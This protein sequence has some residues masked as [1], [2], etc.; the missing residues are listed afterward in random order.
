M[1]V[2][3]GAVVP[4]L[5]I[6]P[7]QH[8]PRHLHDASEVLELRRGHRLQEVM[9]ALQDLLTENS[10]SSRP[11]LAAHPLTPRYFA[12]VGSPDVPGE[13]AAAVLRGSGTEERIGTHDV[14]RALVTALHAATPVEHLV[15]TQQ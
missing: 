4:A 14:R 6:S 7:D 8:S 3:A 9:P 5:G 15:R 2:P 13:G 11:L 12:G 1:G 10:S